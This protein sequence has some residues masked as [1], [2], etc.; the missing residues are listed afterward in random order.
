MDLQ[1]LARGSVL[2]LVKVHIAH[3]QA[4]TRG[5]GARCRPLQLYRMAAKYK[6]TQ[7]KESVHKQIY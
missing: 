7:S 5:G 1:N 6:I 3:C 2:H 4:T